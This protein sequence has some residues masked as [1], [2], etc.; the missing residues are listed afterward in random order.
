MQKAGTSKEKKAGHEQS[1]GNRTKYTTGVRE[2]IFDI[3][4]MLFITELISQ[5]LVN[6][7]GYIRDSIKTATE[8]NEPATR[9]RI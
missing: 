7:H 8:S 6:M 5:R 4:M 1:K 9:L 2:L 3:P